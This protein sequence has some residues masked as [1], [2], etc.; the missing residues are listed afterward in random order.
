MI[1]RPLVVGRPDFRSFFSEPPR[2]PVAHT[3]NIHLDTLSFQVSAH[4]DLS[5]GVRKFLEAFAD[6]FAE[7]L[8]PEDAFYEFIGTVCAQG[9]PGTLLVSNVGQNPQAPAHLRSLLFRPLPEGPR[10]EEFGIGGYTLALRA[11]RIQ[12][13]LKVDGIELTPHVPRRHFESRV[14]GIVYWNWEALMSAADFERLGGLP[15]HRAETGRRL[16]SWFKYLNWKEELVKRNQVFIPYQSWEQKGE[17]LVVFRVRTKDLPEGKKGLKNL[18]VGTL[19][20]DADAE[21]DDELEEPRANRRAR[22]EPRLMVLGNIESWVADG[23]DHTRITVEVDDD[24]RYLLKK[25]PPPERGRLASAIAGDMSTINTQRGG[26]NRLQNNQ[27]FC[28]RLADF[29][30][31]SADAG[32]PFGEPEV[33]PPIEGGRTLNAGQREAVLKAMAA[34]DLCLI[35]GPPGTGKTTVIADLC[36]R[37]AAAGKRVLVASQ[38]NLAVDNALSRLAHIPMVRRLRLGDPGKVDEEFKEFLADYVVESWFAGIAAACRERIDRGAAVEAELVR[39]RT[40]L[41]G[42]ATAQERYAETAASLTGLR[43]TREALNLDVAKCREG[44]AVADA[45]RRAAEAR[46]IALDALLAWCRGE[47]PLPATLSPLAWLVDVAQLRAIAAATDQLAELRAFAEAVSALGAGS[48]IDEASPELAT[49]RK[50][51]LR[52]ADSVEDADLQRLRE[53][54]L[55]LRRLED[56]G[57]ARL[58]RDL[59]RAASAL[60]NWTL[61]DELIIVVDA[62]KPDPSTR[63][64]VENLDTWARDRLRDAEVRLSVRASMGRI[65]EEERPKTEGRVES[66]VAAFEEARTSLDLARQRLEETE[67]EIDRLV[68]EVSAHRGEWARRWQ[69]L[70]P[71]ADTPEPDSAG[72][73][74]MREFVAT[75]EAADTDQRARDRRWR[76]VQQ[77]WV[78]R[79]DHCTEGDREHL[80]DLYTRHSNVVG[81]TCN[82]AGKKQTWN[83]P[84]FRPFDMVIIDEV[85]KATPPELILP[86]L[87]GHKAVLVGDHRQLPPMFREKDASFGEARGEGMISE[88]DFKAYR[89]MV[90]SS[91]FEELFERAP[92]AIKATL[93]TQYRMHP[94]IMAAVNQFYD[95]RLEAGPD[96]ATLAARREHHLTAPD[97]EGGLLIEPSNHLLWLDSSHD[98]D[99]TP[100]FEEQDGTSKRNDFEVELVTGMAVHIG[101][102][103]AR[104]GYVGERAFIVDPND[105]GID[106]AD[107]VRRNLPNMPATTLAELFEERQIRIAGRACKPEGVARAGSEVKVNA[108]REVGILTFY[109]P[110]LKAIREKLQRARAQD[111][112]AFE[113]M[114]LRSNTVDRFQGMEK[115]IIIASLVRST[116]G[117]MGDFV[118]EFQRINVGLSRAQQLLV[119][120][121]A[122]NTWRQAAVPLPPM[123]GGEPVQRLVYDKILDIARENGGKRVVRQLLK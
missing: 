67:R 29:I 1:R 13:K 72:V 63:A 114:E 23:K 5:E 106:V 113:A 43:R 90:T 39:R 115:P 97:R 80:K 14:S 66:S 103:L 121:G 105:D 49:L 47:A 12:G 79:L 122:A 6:D 40:D 58:T 25:S 36:L 4:L 62:I 76:T 77:E 71:D 89:R 44:L 111:K 8:T 10:A 31:S 75:L 38:T 20:P 59:H 55:Q 17:D 87:L 69:A 35:Q 28:T 41:A 91:L 93:W 27:S 22:R 48:A 123:S 24:Q 112:E 45:N 18:E 102:A 32:V 11:V 56:A 16:D 34:P 117:K 82:E 53:V 83:D 21:A 52:L 37:M 100:V 99:G 61:P 64:A 104:L 33:L 51:K 107:L 70:R 78:Q 96:A 116:K 120:V 9:L 95:G 2:E 98:I 7:D 118:R 74:A 108:R 85:S 26:I 94:H 68:A 101:R 19:P 54:N 42:L 110:Q 65:V 73:L 57:W 60:R 88:E 81:M 3:E 119:I 46:S 86:M 30:F 15:F 109:G 92:E 50:E 84:D